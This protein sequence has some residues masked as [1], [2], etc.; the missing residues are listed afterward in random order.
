MKLFV[1]TTSSRARLLGFVHKK[2]QGDVANLSV[3]GGKNNIRRS[4]AKTPLLTLR[5]K[6]RNIAISEA[7]FDFVA[8]TSKCLQPKLENKNSWYSEHMRT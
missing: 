7:P 6:S 4:M 1:H 5:Q 8:S 3:Q 2:K